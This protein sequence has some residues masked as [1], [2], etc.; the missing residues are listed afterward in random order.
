MTTRIIRIEYPG[1]EY[2]EELVSLTIPAEMTAAR[3]H[4]ELDFW[5]SVVGKQDF[6]SRQDFLDALLNAL[7]NAIPGA[8]WEGIAPF[9]T[10]DIVP[11]DQSIN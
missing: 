3:L 2:G 10:L 11:N 9:T 5:S 4:N 7:C 8:S 1:S 6:P